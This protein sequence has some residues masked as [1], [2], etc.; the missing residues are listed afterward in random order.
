MKCDSVK[1]HNI[2]PVIF[3]QCFNPLMNISVWISIL[4]CDNPEADTNIFPAFS[5]KFFL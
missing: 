3:H 5:F 4:K 2:I 1:S